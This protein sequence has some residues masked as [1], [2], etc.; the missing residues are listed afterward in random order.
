MD[1]QVVGIGEACGVG[2]DSRGRAGPRSCSSP[3][4][5]SPGARRNRPAA[6][7]TGTSPRPGARPARRSVLP[8]APAAPDSDR[9]PPRQAESGT[10]MV[11]PGKQPGS[12]ISNMC[13]TITS[14]SPHPEPTLDQLQRTRTLARQRASTPS[15]PVTVTSARPASRR[16]EGQVDAGRRTLTVHL[17]PSGAL[18]PASRRGCRRPLCASTD[19]ASRV[20]APTTRSRPP[21]SPVRL[22]AGTYAAGEALISSL[23]PS[24]ANSAG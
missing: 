14:G 2:G 9:P 1:Q 11:L 6:P 10:G 24:A 15:S 19:Q 17:E 16:F 22:P 21:S 4:W 23:M 13:L 20:S 8:A 12:C 3:S 7:G 5:P 18:P